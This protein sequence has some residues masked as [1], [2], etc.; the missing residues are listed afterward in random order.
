[1]IVQ[2][3]R[4]YDFEQV[5]WNSPGKENECFDPRFLI[6]FRARPEDLHGELL[7]HP[8]GF[9]I[10]IWDKAK[11]S[12][13]HL[14]F[15]RRQQNY[16]SVRDPDGGCRVME[17]SLKTGEDPQPWKI[18]FPLALAGSQSGEHEFAVL[19]DG[20]YFQIL[21]DGIVM[22]RE[23]PEGEPPHLYERPAACT[24]F[25]PALSSYSLTNDLSGIRRTEREIRRDIPIQYYTPF[26]FNTWVGDVVPF[27]WKGRFHIFYLFDRRHHGSRRGKGAHEFWH[28]SSGNFRDWIDHGPVFELEEQWQSAGTGNAFEFQGKLHLSFGWHTER[29]K[30]FPERANQL[31]YR[32]LQL[33]GHTGEF[34]IDEIGSLTPGGASYA[35]SEDGIHF[36]QSRRL[37][38]YLENPSIFVQPDGSLRLCQE[39]IW[40]SDRL[41]NWR[42]VNPDFPPHGKESFAR[43][44]LDCPTRFELDGWEYFMAGFTGFWGRPLDGKTDWIDFAERGWD[45]YDGTCVPMVYPDSRGRLVEGGWINGNGWGSCLLL[46]EIIPLGN[47]RLGKR[48]IEETLPEFEEGT[49]FSGTAELPLTGDVL[50]EFTAASAG[51]PFLL[52]LEGDGTPC[53]FRLDTAE[54]RAQWSAAS[55]GT[56]VPRLPTFREAVLASPEKISH[57]QFPNT[58]FFGR[59]YAKENLNALPPSFRIRL[60][61]HADPKLDAALLDAEID[62]KYTMTTLRTDLKTRSVRILSGAET[63]CL[64]PAKNRIRSAER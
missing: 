51:T 59:D 21:C 48:W 42:P 31:F 3:I 8:C 4:Q 23:C 36:T 26:G 56:P 62:G 16:T 24:V 63:G 55:S 1:M 29:A 2:T 37:M 44:C 30:P 25:S 50:L 57:T 22:D 7:S 20:V 5:T 41:G 45:T 60:L 39:G 47:G 32:N 54:G 49:S 34:G 27:C 38:H 58:P 13:Y 9:S 18:G 6:R 40:E 12:P 14:F 64:R 17:C 61:V 43:N 19:F 10:A 53:E 46:R 15:D 28:L 52:L 11:G 35:V 33:Y